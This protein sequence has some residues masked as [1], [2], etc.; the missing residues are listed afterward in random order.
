MDGQNK[1]PYTDRVYDAA[2]AITSEALS[3]KEA[4]VVATFIAS[5]EAGGEKI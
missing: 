2:K 1:S 3:A 5:Y 4:D